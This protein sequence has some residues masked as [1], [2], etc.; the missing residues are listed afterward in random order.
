MIIVMDTNVLVPGLLRANS[1]PGTIV[2]LVADG[3]LQVA[4]DARILIEY[5]E[6]L[7][8]KKFAFDPESVAY[9][10]KEI[11]ADGILVTA[12]PLN[13]ELPDPEDAP[14]LEIACSLLGTP[15]VTGN[16]KH[17][18]KKAAGNTPILSPKEF[19]HLFA[20]EE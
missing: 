12:K 1:Y 20:A 7:L 10:L 5:K 14:F 11:E 15:L 3:V 17:Y 18:P 8:R 9:I 2:R 6:V 19:I 4:Y 13:K 16:K